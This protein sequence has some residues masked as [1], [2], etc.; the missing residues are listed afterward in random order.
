MTKT[1]T[2]PPSLERGVLAGSV[3]GTS[4]AQMGFLL[5]ERGWDSRLWPWRLPRHCKGSQPG[6]TKGFSQQ[7]WHWS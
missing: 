2:T 3:E 1:T 5:G 4:L 7:L 6:F